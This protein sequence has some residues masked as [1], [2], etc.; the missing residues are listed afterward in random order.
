MRPIIRLMMR[1]G[2]ILQ[3]FQQLIKSVYTEE[4]EREVIVQGGQPTD[5]QISLMTGLHRKEVKRFRE[6]GFEAFIIAPTLSTGS[7]VVTHWLTDRRFQTNR[8]EPKPLSTRKASAGG[9]AELVRSVDPELRPAAV[10]AEMQRIGVVKVEGDHALLIVDSFVPQKGFDDLVQ[11]LAENGHDHLATMVH[12]LSQPAQPML[13]QSVNVT[14]LSAA[15]AEDLERTVRNLWKL[16]M[17][18]IIERAVELEARDK[19]EGNITTRINFGAY[20]Y[21]ETLATSSEEVA[22]PKPQTKTLR[23]KK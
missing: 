4:A 9:F 17:Q 10:L 16:V 13:E 22:A 23:K 14:E 15:S 19:R 6:E 20:F 7:D 5:L 1:R 2:I 18:Q 8:R 12:N 21:R 11:Y 3:T